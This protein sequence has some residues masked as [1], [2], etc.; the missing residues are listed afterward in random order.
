MT[1]CLAMT[2]EKAAVGRARRGER[3][4]GRKPGDRTEKG[5]REEEEHEGEE[6][7]TLFKY[8]SVGSTR[9]RRNGLEGAQNSGKKR[10]R[11]GPSNVGERARETRARSPSLTLPHPAREVRVLKRPAVGEGE[12]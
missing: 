5:R 8:Q 9:T 2:V 3:G 7:P 1:F 4:R 6:V 12:K 10:A 11:L